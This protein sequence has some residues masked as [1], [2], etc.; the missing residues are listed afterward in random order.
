MSRCGQTCGRGGL[1]KPGIL[2][3]HV[4]T[5]LLTKSHHGTTTSNSKGWY[6][7]IFLNPDPTCGTST[8]HLWSTNACRAYDCRL[9]RG[10]PKEPLRDLVSSL[11]CLRKLLLLLLILFYR[12]VLAGHLPCSHSS[13]AGLIQTI[14]YLYSRL[15]W[16]TASSGTLFRRWRQKPTSCKTPLQQP[17]YHLLLR[18]PSALHWKATGTRVPNV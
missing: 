17:V 14:H 6:L 1:T 9:G 13:W 16:L 11:A 8:D 5:I 12:K 2:I 10:S 15:C 4:V 18:N 3:V 7:I